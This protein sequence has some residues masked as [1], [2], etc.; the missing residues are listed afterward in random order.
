MT[1]SVHF[2]DDLA[3]LA[4][5]IGEEGTDRVLAP[6][7]EPGKPSPAEV[8]PEDALCGGH[9][10]P[11]APRPFSA[12]GIARHGK[13]LPLTPNPSPPEYRGRGEKT[14]VQSMSPSAS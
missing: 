3:L 10:P 8:V 4:S 6:K 13:F 11:E 14:A 9:L 2:D 7:L 5:Q 1:F 12:L